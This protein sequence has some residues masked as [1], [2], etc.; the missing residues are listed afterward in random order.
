MVE[1]SRNNRSSSI[2][3]PRGEKECLTPVEG[4]SFRLQRKGPSGQKVNLVDRWTN[5]QTKDLKELDASDTNS[6]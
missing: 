5:G 3:T 1:D 6:I 2:T 4:C